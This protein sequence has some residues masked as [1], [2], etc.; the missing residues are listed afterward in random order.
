MGSTLLVLDLLPLLE[1]PEIAKL[2]LV[3]KKFNSIIDMNGRFGA[4]KTR[5][6]KSK[7]LNTILYF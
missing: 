5:E 2:G 1:I 6:V 7:H 4:G 3:N